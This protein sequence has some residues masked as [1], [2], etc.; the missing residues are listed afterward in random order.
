MRALVLGMEK[1]MKEFSVKPSDSR[2]QHVTE[3]MQKDDVSIRAASTEFKA[4]VASIVTSDVGDASKTLGPS[5]MQFSE[6]S[7]L[8]AKFEDRSGELAR[9]SAA[10]AKEGVNMDAA[11]MTGMDPKYLQIALSVSDEDKA[12]NVPKP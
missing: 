11:Y 5:N 12:R 4:E 3:V 9:V 10:L 6:G 1:D 7:L 8:V 2:S